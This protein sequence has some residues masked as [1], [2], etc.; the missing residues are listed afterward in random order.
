MSL[1]CP[2]INLGEDP[3]SIHN[4]DEEGNADVEKEF[5]G[6]DVYFTSGEDPQKDISSEKQRKR[7]LGS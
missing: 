7:V 4:T 3:K 2:E 5:T 1:Q 6:A